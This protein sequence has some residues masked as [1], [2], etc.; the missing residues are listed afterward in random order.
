M[1]TPHLMAVSFLFL[2]E[3]AIAVTPS[4]SLVLE[5]GS[6]FLGT[7]PSLNRTQADYDFQVDQFWHPNNSTALSIKVI[8][9]IE[10]TSYSIPPDVIC[11]CVV[12]YTP[13]T[14]ST[15]SFTLP[16]TVSAPYGTHN[17]TIGFEYSIDN[18]SYF[19][20]FFGSRTTVHVGEMEVQSINGI[21]TVTRFAADFIVQYGETVFTE[22]V[23]PRTGYSSFTQTFIE[24]QGNWHGGSLRYQ[25]DT[26]AFAF[27]TPVPE[28]GIPLQ[29]LFGL[30]LVGLFV[31]YGHSQLTK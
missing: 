21:E 25:S 14:V 30:G 9:R 5:Y 17:G 10:Q 26:Q 11:A 15:F 16:L 2:A 23:D 7:I 12:S 13:T 1:K 24:H 29:M 20:D 4:S 19:E 3:Q 8:E 28:P 18:A 27:L 31:R 6:L 22:S